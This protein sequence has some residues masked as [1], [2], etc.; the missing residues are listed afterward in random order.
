MNG[1]LAALIGAV[2]LW[3]LLGLAFALFLMIGGP[4]IALSVM[5]NVRGI[6]QQLERLND[7]L[8]RRPF[9]A[10]QPT[11]NSAPPDDIPVHVPAYRVRTGPLDIQ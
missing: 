5:R 3:W 8:E 1:T 7:T 11:G 10:G 2:G 4:L 9:T 6:R